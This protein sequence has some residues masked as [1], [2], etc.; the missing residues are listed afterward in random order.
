MLGPDGI[1]LMGGVGDGS[2]SAESF[3]VDLLNELGQGQLPWLL[4]IIVN[5]AQ[6]CWIHSEFAGHLHLNVRQA[7]A[8]SRIFPR[9]HLLLSLFGV[10]SI[11][12]NLHFVEWQSSPQSLRASADL[13]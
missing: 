10:H 1:T 4:L 12:N 9:L 7:V 11:N 8:F 2:S 3:E 13:M 6:L 5:F